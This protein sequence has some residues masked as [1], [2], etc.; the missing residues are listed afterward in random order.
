VWHGPVLLALLALGGIYIAISENLSP[1]PRG[2]I[3][4]LI[5]VLLLP[6]GLSLRMGHVQITRALAFAILGLLTA[7]EAASASLLVLNL[8]ANILRLPDLPHQAALAL[9]RDAGLIWVANVLTFALWY[10]EIDGGGPGRRRHEPYHSDDFVFPQMTLDRP[11]GAAWC[12]HFVDYLF[13]AFNTSTAFS[14]TDTLILS[15]RA[16]LLLM[17]QSLISLVVLAILA[18]RAINTL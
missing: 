17:T 15:R 9:L 1:G 10:W 2:L 7:A 16:K 5:V 6:F 14:P 13:L 11:A 8:A 18:A 4:A 3:L 12:P